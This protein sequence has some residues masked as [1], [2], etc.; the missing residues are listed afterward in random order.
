MPYITVEWLKGRSQEQKRRIAADI[1]DS[2]IR[3]AK[4]KPDLIN[5]IFTD[6]EAA[7]CFAGPEVM[8]TVSSDPHST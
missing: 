7:D 3:H 8:T 5:V 6:R 2:F 1:T 4:V